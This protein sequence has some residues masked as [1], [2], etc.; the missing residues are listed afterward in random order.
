MSEA[1]APLS[2]PDWRAIADGLSQAL[3]SMPCR[4]SRDYEMKVT[5]QCAR[6]KNLGSYDLAVAHTSIVQIPSVTH[7]R[8]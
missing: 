1:A 3:R 8:P 2:P 5:E 4:C 6:C 7:G